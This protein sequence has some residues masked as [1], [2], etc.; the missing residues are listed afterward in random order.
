MCVIS[1]GYQMNENLLHVLVFGNS[2]LLYF[3]DNWLSKITKF[4][5][6]HKSLMQVAR[7]VLL[8]STTPLATTALVHELAEVL[9]P[10]LH[11]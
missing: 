11:H 3:I 2:Y 4:L 10:T 8:Y 5:I 7:F 1:L 9:P 6:Y